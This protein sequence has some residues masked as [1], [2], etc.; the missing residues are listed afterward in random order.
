[1]W[2]AGIEAGDEATQSLKVKYGD[3]LMIYPRIP[4]EELKELYL[5]TSLLI[6]ASYYESFGLAIAEAMACGVAVVA[7]KTGYAWELVDGV[8]FLHIKFGDHTDVVKK[9]RCLWMDRTLLGNIQKNGQERVQALRWA[10][11]L[12]RLDSYYQKIFKE[13]APCTLC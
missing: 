3:R 4:K 5:K 10:E 6:S 8:D 12:E 11:N 2:L 9:V 7:T 13:T 1:V